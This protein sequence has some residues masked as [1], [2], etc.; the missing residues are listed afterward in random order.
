MIDFFRVGEIVFE[1]FKPEF[2]DEKMKPMDLNNIIIKQQR[3]MEEG[4]KN[5]EK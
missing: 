4:E 1:T 3:K 5:V 2:K